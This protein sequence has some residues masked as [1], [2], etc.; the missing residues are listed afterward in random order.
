MKRRTLSVITCLVVASN[1]NAQ[2]PSNPAA[3]PLE[4]FAQLPMIRNAKLSPDGTHLAYIRPLNGR[5]H[6]F[7]QTLDGNAEK[8]VIMPPVDNVDYDWFRWANEDRI[9][10]S[11]SAMDKR[12]ITETM[13]TRLL[14][15]NRD[16]SD[17]A[18]IVKPSTG[19]RTGSA[20]PRD[21]DPPQIQDD[22]IHWLPD[23]P[24]HILVSVDGDH[25]AADE[26]RIVDI[27]D[28]EYDI[29][30]DD[31]AGVQNWLT[32]QDGNLRLGWGYRNLKFVMLVK[33]ENGMW[34][35]AEKAAWFEADFFPLAFTDSPDIAYM[36]GP[37]ER[38]YAVVKTVNVQTDEFLETVFEMD[39]IDAEGLAYD[40]VTNLPAGVR[41]IDDQPRVQYFD[42]SLA[43]LQRAIDAALPHTSNAIASMTR[44]RRKVLIRSSS[45]VDPGTYSFLDRDTGSLSLVA[46][47]MPGLPPEQ[48]SPVEPVRYRAR[49]GLPIHAYLTLPRGNPR[50]NLPFVIL[51]HGGPAARDYREFWFLSQFIA[52]RGYAVLQPNFRGSTGYGKAF[53]DAGKNEWGGK[54]QEDVT[55]GVQW[56]ID[57]GIA[58]PERI[59]IAGW[60]YGGYSAAMGAVQTPDLYQCAA[61]INGVLNLPRMIADDRR[62]IGGSVWTRHV[63]LEDESARSVSPYHQADRIRIPMLIIQAQDDAR[64]HLDQGRRMARRLERDGK[65]VEYVEIELGGHSMDNEEARQAILRSLEAFLR[66][67]LGDA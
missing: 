40:P 59:C 46:E 56:L 11:I 67:N 29:A 18:R 62:Y 58:D 16:A 3:I 5:G 6:L 32:D 23:Q 25:N 12:G 13:E 21:L 43:G 15:M 66:A 37:N 24:H 61:S 52:S 34:R 36:I 26:V 10:F 48:M 44:D 27:R 45:D 4:T 50:E 55:D 28:G 54:M 20:L 42:E 14:A 35:S 65:P 53:E 47:V 17:I 8:P 49:D 64:V 19:T 7:V 63:G 33:S 60:S 1:A 9:V 38:S 22:V 57:E 39:G 30:R 31:H 51:P 41:Y 2:G